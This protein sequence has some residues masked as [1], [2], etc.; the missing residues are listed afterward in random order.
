MWLHDIHALGCGVQLCFSERECRVWEPRNVQPDRE[1]ER[2]RRGERG[3]ERER[4]VERL[5]GPHSQ[6]I[7]WQTVIRC[8]F[9]TSESAGA[10]PPTRSTPRSTPPT[11]PEQGL[12]VN[13]GV[14]AVQWGWERW[15]CPEVV[16]VVVV[17]HT[18]MYTSH[19]SSSQIN[20]EAATVQIWKL[21]LFGIIE[22][23]GHRFLD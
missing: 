4:G 9:L 8:K 7:G 17:L 20:Y 14:W 2:E 15:R 19:F 21:E 6:I 11:H 12:S 10:S 22:E 13:A 18:L 16:V 3:R 1:R 5:S 23:S